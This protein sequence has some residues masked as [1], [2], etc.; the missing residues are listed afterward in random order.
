MA[1]IRKR[2]L[3]HGTA[4]EVLFSMDGRQRSKY[5]PPEVPYQAVKEFAAK[6]EHDKAYNRAGLD[7]RR[8]AVSLTKL[9]A[10]Y[11]ERRAKEVSTWREIHALEL[12]IKFAGDLEADRVTPEIITKFR[13]SLLTSRMKGDEHKA[14][15][16]V[17]KDLRNLRT[18]F[19][20]AHRNNIISTRP[21]DRITFFKANPVI[22]EILTRDELL[23]FYRALP[24]TGYY[25][26]FF[27]FMRYTGR[28]RSEILRLTF[29]DIDLQEKTIRLPSRKTGG[30]KKIPMH[31]RLHRI[32][33]FIDFAG[34]RDDLIFPVH[35]DTI[36]HGF[37][38]ALRHAGIKKSMPTHVLRHTY[39]ARIIEKYLTTGDAERIA[40]EALDHSTRAMTKHYTQIV[41]DQLRK[42]INEVDF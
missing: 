10:I 42:A 34:G 28:R 27:V 39:G 40:Q 9:K 21:F 4:H 22:P 32:L 11:S 33:G 2:K 1:H 13:D 8:P 16:G 6:I 15:R 35:K 26:M 29:G 14:R 17:N 12:L 38:D 19:N 37:R 25:R 3:K 30:P 20:W 23:R 41:S 18:V 36:S 31:T 5:F 7:Q 24:K